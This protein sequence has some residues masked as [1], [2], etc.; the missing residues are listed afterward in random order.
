MVDV[1]LSRLSWF[2]PGAALCSCRPT[3]RFILGGNK[4]EDLEVNTEDGGSRFSRNFGTYLKPI[5]RHILQYG[6][7]QESVSLT[8]NELFC[9]YFW[10]DAL[11]PDICIL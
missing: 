2:Y 6:N 10:H 8:I 3:I 9:N 11:I 5:W 4:L 7:G 1:S